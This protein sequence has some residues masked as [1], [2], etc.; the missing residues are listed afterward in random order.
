[1]ETKLPKA[2]LE[3]SE[4]MRLLRAMQEEENGTAL[5][6]E[7]ELM[8][9]SLLDEEGEKTISEIA[10][11]IPNV[12]FSTVSTDIT[13]LWRDKKMLNKTIDPDN[14]R[15]TNVSLTEKG[16]ETMKT[17]KQQRAERFKKLFV[18]ID[19]SDEEKEALLRIVNRA[20]QYF[21]EIL[22]LNGQKEA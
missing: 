5:L 6:T 20:V 18:A 21:D 19:A 22:G 14:Q 17:A 11:C 2:I 3:L 9:L 16:K 15:T 13:R 7:R 1:M 8:I 12:S 4:R 10:E